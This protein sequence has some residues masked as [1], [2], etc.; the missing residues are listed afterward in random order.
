LVIR[1]R[2]PRE[3]TPPPIIIREAPPHIPHVDTNPQY[4]TRVVRQTDA[5]YSM[6]QQYQQTLNHQTVDYEQ[7]NGIQ[8][9]HDYTHGTNHFGEQQSTAWITELVSNNGA[10]STAPPHLLGRND[11]F[12]FVVV[13]VIVVFNRFSR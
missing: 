9:G 12:L 11:C 10:T 13:V 7:F 1:T 2:A 4:M 8:N 3:K 6:P 5:S